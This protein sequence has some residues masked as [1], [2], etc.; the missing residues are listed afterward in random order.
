[1]ALHAN[2]KHWNS[3]S[4]ICENLRNLWIYLRLFSFALLFGAWINMDEV[5]GH[6]RDHPR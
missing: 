6:I 4:V 5:N 1:L 3:I 2:A